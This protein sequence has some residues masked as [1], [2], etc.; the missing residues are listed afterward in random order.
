M[1][2]LVFQPMH[3]TCIVA[4]YGDNWTAGWSVVQTLLSKMVCMVD[5]CGMEVCH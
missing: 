4:I 1:F 3:M 5:V 2:T